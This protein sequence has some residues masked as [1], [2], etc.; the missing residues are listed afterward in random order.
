MLRKLFLLLTIL[1]MLGISAC[2]APAPEAEFASEQ[3]CENLV[4]FNQSLDTLNNTS[5]FA[6]QAALEAQFEVVRRNFNALV[7]A[8]SNLSITEKDDFENA[9]DSLMETAGSLPEDLSVSDTL[10]A[11]K[12]PLDQVREAADNLKTGLNCK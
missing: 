12:D 10:T 3:V 9:V 1:T 4:L 6:D 8:V 7:G 5:Q 11:L 2:A